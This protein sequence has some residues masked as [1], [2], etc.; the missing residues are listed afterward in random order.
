MTFSQ[1]KR[2]LSTQERYALRLTARLS[3][4]AADLPY[5]IAERLRAGREQ[6]LAHRRKPV[7][8]T[9]LAAA[10]SGISV[11]GG[12]ATLGF[13]GNVGG[14]ERPGWLTR[15]ASV[16]PVIA[17]VVGLFT[18]NMVQNEL[19]ADELAEVDTAILTD[20][21][22]PAAYTDPGFAQ[23]LKTANTTSEASE[24]AQ[25]QQQQQQ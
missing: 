12:V 13:G 23:F 11:Q 7:S 2:N 5:D 15:I 20:D 16:L 4:A 25:P 22:P 8:L 6:A 19:R 17:L 21:L 3:G 9:R 24:P 18:I 1:H 10:T 14:D